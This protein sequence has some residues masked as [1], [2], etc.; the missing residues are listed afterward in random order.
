MAQVVDGKKISQQI[1]TRLKKQVIGLKIKPHLA[2]VLVGNDPAS[3]LY[4]NRKA[5]VAESI[6]IKFIL[7]KLPATISQNKLIVAI[8][9]LQQ[10]NKLQGLIVQ[11]PLPSKISTDE[12]LNAIQPNIDVDCLT[13]INLGKLITGNYNFIPPTIGAILEI[14]KRYK[15]KLESQH[16]VVVGAGRLVGKPLINML[17]NSKATVSVCNA[18]TKNL[19]KITQQ[20]D[21][22]ITGVGK[23]KIISQDYIKKGAVVI[24]AGSSFVHHKCCGD[25]NCD[26]IKHKAKL[27][28]PT[29]GGVGPITVAKLLENTINNC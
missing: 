29:P 2:V 13:E 22:L 26:K 14:F 19:K 16:I 18:K 1:L 11:L 7:E 27:I 10:K 24:D 25:V 28:T 4:V 9:N 20:A 23:A 17:L 8:Q 5:K 3:K 21:I 6:G 15:I 12:V